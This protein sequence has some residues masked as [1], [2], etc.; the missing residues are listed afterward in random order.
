M[1]VG[2]QRQGD[3]RPDRPSG[4][5]PPR[6]PP[7]A[8]AALDFYREGKKSTVKVVLGEQPGEAGPAG[9]SS[10]GFRVREVKPAEGEPIVMIDAVVRGSLAGRV[11]L[12]PGLRVVG[13]GRTDVHT[14]AEFDKAAAAYTPE[15]GLPLR[16]QT[17]DGRTAFV[18]LGGPGGPLR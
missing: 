2:A 15:Q 6:S 4:S 18:T 3:P 8:E 9:L 7:G 12:V 11:G 14:K 16:I 5:Q 10:F 13:V 17:P 1:I